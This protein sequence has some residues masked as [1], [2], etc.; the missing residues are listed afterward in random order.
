M[1]LLSN[2]RLSRW[3][4]RISPSY[5][6]QE[7]A[8]NTDYSYPIAESAGQSSRKVNFCYKQRPWL[9]SCA[10]SSKIIDLVSR[11]NKREERYRDGIA[12]NVFINSK[13]SST[14]TYTFSH[15][16]C[17]RTIR[18]MKCNTKHCVSFGCPWQIHC[19]QLRTQEFFSGGFNKFS[20]GQR[21]ERMG[22]W[23]R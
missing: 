2:M 20:W 19:S 3:L 6:K 7:A 12:R 11:R 8:P 10:D 4:S 9:V 16:S 15:A 23:G 13:N 21:T 1:E 17:T 14:P 18:F 5:L 22:I